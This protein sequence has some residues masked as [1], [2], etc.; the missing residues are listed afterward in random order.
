MDSRD[1]E[2]LDMAVHQ[3]AEMET[4]LADTYCSVDTLPKKNCLFFLIK[5]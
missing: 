2:Q 5:F 3:M 4:F 1:F